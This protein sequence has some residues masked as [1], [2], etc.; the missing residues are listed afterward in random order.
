[1]CSASSEK[2]GPWEL[3]GLADNV[4]E[5]H[6]VTECSYGDVVG[7]G[8]IEVS[9]LII[10]RLQASFVMCVQDTAQNKRNVSTCVS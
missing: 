10:G 2:Y 9:T 8:E 4:A 6:V 1:M 3:D 5:R 7:G